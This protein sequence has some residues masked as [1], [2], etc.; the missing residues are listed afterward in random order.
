MKALI[1]FF[2][3]IALVLVIAGLFYMTN[4]RKKVSLT[5]QHEIIF[6][7]GVVVFSL[8]VTCL[9]LTLSIK[10]GWISLIVWALLCIVSIFP[11][12]HYLNKK[13]E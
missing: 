7:W 11:L 10:K 9:Y 6:L 5:K 3:F 13:N 12:S 8:L 4:Y 1:A 2:V